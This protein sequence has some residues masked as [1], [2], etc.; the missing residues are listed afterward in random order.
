MCAERKASSKQAQHVH[1]HTNRLTD[2]LTDQQ[3]RSNAQDWKH[4]CTAVRSRSITN[5]ARPARKI[6]YLSSRTHKSQH[7]NFQDNIQEKYFKS[8]KSIQFKC[9][10]QD[11]ISALLCDIT[12]RTEV[13]PYRRLGTT[14]QSR[15]QGAIG[16]PEMSVRNYFCALRN[17]AEERRSQGNF[18]FC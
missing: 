18:M 14:C 10:I 2:C 11:M 7:L 8:Q 12:Q 13:I 17:V 4:F 9:S 3:T 16:C 1:T 5:S 6:N 15:L